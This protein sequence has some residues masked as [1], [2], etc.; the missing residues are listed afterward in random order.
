MC[1]EWVR[2]LDMRGEEKDGRSIFGLEKKIPTK[3]EKGYD[4][5]KQSRQLGSEVVTRSRKR[6]VGAVVEVLKKDKRGHTKRRASHRLN[7]ALVWGMVCTGILRDSPRSFNGA[8]SAF[9]S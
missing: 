4:Q 6:A 1:V 8:E 3:T 7:S 2:N 5:K 9:P